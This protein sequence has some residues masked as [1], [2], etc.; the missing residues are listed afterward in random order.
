[1]DACRPNF[2]IR[3]TPDAPG[4]P[5]GTISV[6]EVHYRFSEHV[7]VRFSDTIEGLAIPDGWLNDDTLGITCG[8]FESQISD[9]ECT[10]EA[11]SEGPSFAEGNT[12]RVLDYSPPFILNQTGTCTPS[13]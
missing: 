9:T 2:P 11:S 12:W 7:Y 3:L 5:P 1:M 13:D 4:P 10:F 8:A 6:E